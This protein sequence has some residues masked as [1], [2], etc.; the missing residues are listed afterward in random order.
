MATATASSAVLL[1]TMA[2]S[3]QFDS[4]L[5]AL[6]NILYLIRRSLNDPAKT[7]KYLDIADQLL[8]DIAAS[9]RVH[10]VHS[11]GD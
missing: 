6:S 11:P 4:S 1:S 5:E 7:T 2:T 8:V 9:R 3:H 10:P